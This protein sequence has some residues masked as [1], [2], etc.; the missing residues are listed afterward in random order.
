M[1]SNDPDRARDASTPDRA[2]RQG[3]AHRAGQTLGLVGSLALLV[4]GSLALPDTA[5]AQVRETPQRERNS[6]G[7]PIANPGGPDEGWSA[8]AGIGFTANPTTF[9]MNLEAQYA[10]SEWIAVGPMLQLGLDDHYAIV[11]PTMNV[12]FKFADLP[13]PTFDR[14]IPYTFG[15]LGLAVINDDRARNDKTSTGFMIDLGAGIEYQL[16]DNLFLGTQMMFD[17]LP[18]QTQ[19][20]KFIYAWQIGGLRYAF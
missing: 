17:F 20:Q 14:L 3:G 13:G 18:Q 10:F 12:T 2:P 8:R 1:Q 7:S 16:T 11:A 9:L 4:G 15:G 19:G 5:G 6:M